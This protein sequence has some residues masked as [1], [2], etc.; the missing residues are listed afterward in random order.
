[1]DDHPVG[2][3]DTP[4]GHILICQH[5]RPLF[6]HDVHDYIIEGIAK[7]VDGIHVLSVIRTGGGKSSY[8]SGFMLLLQAL[9]KDATYKKSIP[10]NPLMIIV[11]PTKGLEEEQVRP[12]TLD[13]VL[14]LILLLGR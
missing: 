9:Q 6:P 1:M 8:F 11:Y 5:L 7:A 2:T 14:M 13:N 3:L 10:E 4:E 12:Q